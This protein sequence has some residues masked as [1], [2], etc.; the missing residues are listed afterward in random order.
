MSVFDAYARYYDLVNQKKVYPAE[1]QYVASLIQDHGGETST[2]LDI[3]CGTGRH[4][5]LLAGSVQEHQ[6]PSQSR[7]AVRF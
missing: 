7:G 2:L 5:E 4:A 3:G 6:E 1:A